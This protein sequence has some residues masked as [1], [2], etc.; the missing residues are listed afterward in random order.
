MEQKNQHNRAYILAIVFGFA[1]VLAVLLKSPI[2]AES[3]AYAMALSLVT[4]ITVK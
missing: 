3:Y 1:L 4:A 2:R